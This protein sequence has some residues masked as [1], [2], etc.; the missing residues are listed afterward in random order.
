MRESFLEE[1]KAQT[2]Q[3]N[4]L[5]PK[6]M[7][8]CRVN[9]YGFEVTN[10]HC[11]HLWALLLLFVVIVVVKYCGGA[12]EDG[13]SGSLSKCAAETVVVLGRLRGR[14][15]VLVLKGLAWLGRSGCG[16]WGSSSCC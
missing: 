12:E 10:E 14:V 1:A 2:R 11:L 8:K 16:C 6:W 3:R 13:T 15:M 4:S 9:V 7:R 5:V